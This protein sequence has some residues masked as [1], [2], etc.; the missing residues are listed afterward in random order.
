MKFTAPKGVRFGGDRFDMSDA[1]APHLDV[2]NTIAETLSWSL[3][4]HDENRKLVALLGCKQLLRRHA[5]DNNGLTAKLYAEL[6]AAEKMPAALNSCQQ[7]LPSNYHRPTKVYSIEN[8]S[9]V[10]IASQSP[11]AGSKDVDEEKNN[12]DPLSRKVLNQ[13]VARNPNPLPIKNTTAKDNKMLAQAEKPNESKR[14]VSRF[15]TASSRMS[16]YQTG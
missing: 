9:L 3:D 15:E 10:S 4:L 16:R 5:L 6:D 1:L 13:E 2:V 14:D 8:A 12:T 11:T 7:L